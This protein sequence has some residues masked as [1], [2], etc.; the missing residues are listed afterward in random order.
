MLVVDVDIKRG[1]NVE[2]I[3]DIIRRGSVVLSETDLDSWKKVNTYN[4]DAR[5]C[6][7]KMKIVKEIQFGFYVLNPLVLL[8]MLMSCGNEIF[9]KPALAIVIL[10][11][12]L[13][14]FIFAMTKNNLIVHT[15]TTALM[16]ILD[17]RF[18]ILLV[19]NIILSGMKKYIEAPLEKEIDYP[20]FNDINVYYEEVNSVDDISNQKR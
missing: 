7:Q 6:R 1:E 12:Q 10:A 4:E 8:G 5:K 16:L 18:V 14:A 11:I 13:V 15:I 3:D 9:E 2:N 17:I 19:A 20:L